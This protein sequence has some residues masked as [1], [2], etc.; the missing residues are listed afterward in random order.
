MRTETN[1]RLIGS[2]VVAFV[3]GMAW[4]QSVSYKNYS[5]RATDPGHA[6]VLTIS[7][8]FLR[9]A[10]VDLSTS[11]RTQLTAEETG[12]HGA[13]RPLWRIR[14]GNDVLMKL[15][16][17]TRQIVSMHDLAREEAQFKGL[18]K[19][20]KPLI[21]TREDARRR[22]EAMARRLGIP[23]NCKP[24]SFDFK[25]NPDDLP[26]SSGRAGMTFANPKG[27]RIGG[28]SIDLL[29]G[30]I[31]G[32]WFAPWKVKGVARKTPTG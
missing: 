20:R 11:K 27:V 31:N 3:F 29:D 15:D 14:F 16:M 9:R 25:Q 7:K 28:L 32:Y 24:D 19:K 8:G 12:I 5:L 6:E 10:N 22:V 2:L 23:A 26:R 21:R 30:G 18:Q 17:Q 4:C 13:R 1:R